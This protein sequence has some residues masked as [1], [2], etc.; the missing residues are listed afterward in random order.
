MSRSAPYR[1]H[2]LG[3]DDGPVEKHAPGAT[4]PVV[5]VMMEGAD[6][7]EAVAVTRFAVDGEDATG[8]LAD[9]IG[10]LRFRPSLQGVVLGGITIAGLAV[11]D[12]RGLSE[13]VGLPVITV[14]RRSPVDPP[15]VAALRS[16]GFAHRVAVV[17][18]APGARPVAGLF[19]SAAGAPDER[20][21]ALLAAVSGKSGLP[22]PLRVA[23]LV[24]RALVTGE[25][26]GKP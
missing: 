26:R 7:F 5:G 18:A 6:V 22:E 21:D 11:V 10:S 4:T 1:P 15:L 23:H 13:R 14:N 24:A 8:F 9:W 25:S 19:A 20:I 2:V 16:A 12:V 3:I 17:E